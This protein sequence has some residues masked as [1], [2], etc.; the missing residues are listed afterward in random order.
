MTRRNFQ[1]TG[2]AWAR[3]AAGVF[4]APRQITAR[5]SRGVVIPLGQRLSGYAGRAAPVITGSQWLISVA[6]S[7]RTSL[8]RVWLTLLVEIIEGFG[9]VLPKDYIN[10]QSQIE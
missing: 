1:A 2:D 4:C 7:A 5:R 9:F 8:T 3:C 10:K 6:Q